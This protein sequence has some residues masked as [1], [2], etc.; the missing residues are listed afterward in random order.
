MSHD[1]IENPPSFPLALDNS[2][3]ST[4]RSCERK[5]MYQYKYHLKPFGANIHLVAGG[6]Y[7][8]ALEVFRLSFYQFGMSHEDSLAA[9]IYEGIKEWGDNDTFEGEQ[10]SLWNTLYAVIAH[11]EEYRPQTDYIQPLFVRGKPAVEFTFALPLDE[12]HPDYHQPVLYT[13][14]FDMLAVF[15]DSPFVEDDKT[16][17]TLGAQWATQWEMSSQITGYVWAARTFGHNVAGAILRGT[18]IQTY[19]IKHAVSTQY[20]D[21]NAINR[22]MWQTLEDTRRL[23]QVWYTDD[24]W[25]YNLGFECARCPYRVLCRAHDWREWV[26]GNF[27]VRI[28][29]PLAINKYSPDHAKELLADGTT[30]PDLPAGGDL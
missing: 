17:A 1:I 21:D 30:P 28:W 23:K 8:K 6:T 27:E 22:W 10:K 11:F 12:E 7:A 26:D 15:N 19:D 9:A 18:S 25:H 20:R 5:A 16:A 3:L 29:D 14:R 13:G 4:F 2:T 24:K